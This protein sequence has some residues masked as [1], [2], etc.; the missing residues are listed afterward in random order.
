MSN[1]WETAAHIGSLVGIF[2]AVILYIGNA[3]ATRLAHM[4]KLFG[5]YLRMRFDHSALG[6][7]SGDLHRQLTS[8]KLYSLEEMFHWVRKERSVFNFPKRRRALDYWDETIRDHL[9]E[10]RE[11]AAAE[12]DRSGSCYTREF[13]TL[14]EE[15]PF[16]RS[17]GSPSL[18]L[19]L[20]TAITAWIERQP[21]PKPTRS[22]AIR[23]LIE[24]GLKSKELGERDG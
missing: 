7:S 12:F 10:D 14:W 1:P 4:H 5:D 3:K 22:E 6:Q 15:A 9:N 2:V 24:K 13:I 16:R 21:K 20:E 11:K 18:H 23:R 17:S 8:F 19:Q